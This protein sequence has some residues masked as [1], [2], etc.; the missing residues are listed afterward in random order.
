[1][2]RRGEFQNL[3]GMIY[4][5]DGYGTYPGKKPVYD[6]AF[7]FMEE[8]YSDA[9]VPPWAIK[10]VIRKEDLEEEKGLDLTKEFIW[11]EEIPKQL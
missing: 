5:T 8:D 6:T 4:F 2:I 1:M 7:V 10:L 11:G 9:Q 3:K